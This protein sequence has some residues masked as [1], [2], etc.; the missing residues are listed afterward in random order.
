M[1]LTIHYA[2]GLSLIQHKKLDGQHSNS[3]TQHL[4]IK[5]KDGELQVEMFSKEPLTFQLGESD[6]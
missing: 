5:H 6:D 1:D 3:L 4:V 2:E